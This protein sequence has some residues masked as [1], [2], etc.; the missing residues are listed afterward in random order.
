MLACPFPAQLSTWLQLNPQ[1]LW[2]G[3][4]QSAQEGGPPARGGASDS[5]RERGAG[6]RRASAMRGL[7]PMELLLA[8]A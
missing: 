5:R 2:L 6:G 4:R 1:V 3:G 7:T 8:Q